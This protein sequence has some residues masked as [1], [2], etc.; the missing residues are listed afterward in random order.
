M[1][2]IGSFENLVPDLIQVLLHLIPSPVCCLREVKLIVIEMNSP[3]PIQ[4]GG[5]G[6]TPVF[7][8]VAEVRTEHRSYRPFLLTKTGHQ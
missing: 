4:T 1:T 7:H 6:T 2:D 8:Y 3:P 5:A